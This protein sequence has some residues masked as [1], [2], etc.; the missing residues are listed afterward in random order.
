[1]D[2]HSNPITHPNA[3][4]GIIGGG[5]LGRMLV[6]AAARL[7]LRAIVLD[8]DEDSPAGQLGLRHVT[9]DWRDA[10]KLAELVQAST[11][12]TFDLEDIDAE[13]LLEL[14]AQGHDIHPSPQVLALL[15]DKLTQ[16]QALAAAGIPTAEFIA[17]DDPE[18]GD[19]E[20]V[21]RQFGYPLVQK[22]RRG[23][24]DGR[25]VAILRNASEFEHCLK[26][27][28]LLERYVENRKELAVMAARG[29]DG[30][31]QCYPA[32][33][34]SFQETNTLD[35]LLAPARV[36]NE[37]AETARD[38]AR[39]TVEALGGVGVF[40]VEL[41]LTHE[42][43]LLVNE[44]APRTHNSGH[45]TIEACYTDQ[46]EQHLRAVTGLPLGSTEQMRP[47]VMLN[48]LGEPGYA[49]APVIEGLETAL[50]IPGVC[51]HI[52]G[53]ETTRPHRKMGHVTVLGEDLGTAQVK[54]AR[55]REMIRVKGAETLL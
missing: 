51:I 41:F 28:S 43:R 22:A 34:M 33:E 4:L 52:Y 2:A 17:L 35:L 30:Q 37:I 27:P 21:F 12:S 7:G 36:S 3:R 13:A 20:E 49:G 18:A 45:Y 16:K 5:Q 53:K 40:G 23:G 15:Q 11:V 26:T 31:I 29:R 46:F 25:G 9:G 1:M 39:H 32:V 24:Y 50:A 47:A 42:D 14:E 48:L 55:V 44:V 6:M 10:A 8:P 38:L 19:A 54:A